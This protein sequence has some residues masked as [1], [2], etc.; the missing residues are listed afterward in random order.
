MVIESFFVFKAGK[1]K[2]LFTAWF[3][4]C[5]F[6]F[7]VWAGGKLLIDYSIIKCGFVL[8]DTLTVSQNKNISFI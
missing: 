5:S 1:C 2:N 3:S 4:K 7:F 6:L 8:K